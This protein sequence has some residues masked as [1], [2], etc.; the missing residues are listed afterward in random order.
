MKQVISNLVA[1]AA[2]YGEPGGPVVVTL[3][4]G[5]A[6]VSLSV[7]NPGPMIPRAAIESLFE[8]LRRGVGSDVHASRTS[9]GLGLFIVRQVAQ[10]HGGTVAV[11]SAGGRTVFKVALPRVQQ[12]TRGL[13]LPQAC[14]CG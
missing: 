2:R 6:E 7:E 3:S 12:R 5:D 4:G 14:K 8:P 9:M 13:S 11:D 1:N 10:A